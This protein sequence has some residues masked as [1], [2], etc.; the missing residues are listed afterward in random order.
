MRLLL[1]AIIL[2]FSFTFAQAQTNAKICFPSSASATNCVPVT[3]TNPFPVNASVSASIAGFQPA[4]AYATITAAGTS[5]SVALPTNTGT[6][7]FDNTGTTAV[8]CTLGVGSATAVASQNIIQPGSGKAFTVGTNT[9]AA[10]ID[11]TGS[12]S[13]VVVL[14]GGSGLATGWGGGS[15]GGGSGGSVTQGTD[16]W[17]VAGKGTAGSP[18][19]GVVSVQ[20]VS[21]G[22]VL[23]INIA[24]GQIAS[25]AVASG[26]YAAGSLAAGAL[27]TGSG[28]DGWDL[29]Q[30]TKADAVCTL[31]ATTAPCTI[32]SLLK[33]N[34]NSTNSPIPQQVG[35]LIIGGVGIDQTT[36]GTTNAISLKYINTTA[37]V[38]GGLAGTLGVGGAVATNVAITDNP[39]NLGAQAIAAE[40][41]AVTA[42]RKVQL[43]ADLTGKLINLPYA[44]PENGLN[45]EITSAM[46]GTTSTALTGMGAQGSGVR[47]Y[48]TQCTFSNTHATVGTMINLQDGS[49]GSVLW[50]APAAAVY[51]GAVVV[52]PSPIKTTANTGLFAVN[53]TTGSSTFVSCTGFKGI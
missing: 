33:A 30:G 4:L 51:G 22:T 24:S 9:F 29:T 6:V 42:T 14:S 43:V 46:T 40:N 27:S 19:G 39:L 52:F 41:T 25:G 7:V 37:V 35:T 8:S 10:C 53:A 44:N 18:S 38:T 12:A 23:P 28:V 47:V 20:G 21:S 15:S 50:Q 16:P 36:V 31:P 26:A 11:Q 17:L 32:I 3:A 1:A 2:T 49:G 48:A 45:G 5:G 34:A 13:N